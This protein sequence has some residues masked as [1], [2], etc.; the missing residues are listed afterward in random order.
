[1]K[2]YPVPP[3]VL[4]NIPQEKEKFENIWEDVIKHADALAPII[5]REMQKIDGVKGFP[6]VEEH[7][8]RSLVLML[9]LCFMNTSELDSK[10]LDEALD[11]TKQVAKKIVEMQ[12]TQFN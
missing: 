8:R 12:R 2:K 11:A 5:M 4:G 10:N 6:N 7:I 1:M 9:I 3:I